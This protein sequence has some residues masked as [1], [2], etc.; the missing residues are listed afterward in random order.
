MFRNY[1]VTAIRHLARNKLYAGISIFGLSIGLCMALFAGLMIYQELSFEHFLPNYQRTFVAI[2]GMAPPDRPPMYFAQSPGFVAASMKRMFP[3]IAV[4]S[5]IADASVRLRRGQFET[6]EKVYWADPEVFD[7]LSFTAIAGD[8]RSALKRPDGIVLTQSIATRY[9]G[10]ENP[11]GQSLT[12]NGEHLQ[13]VTAVIR[14]LPIYG[15]SLESGIFVSGLAPY[16]MLAKCDHDDIENAKRGGVGLCGLTLFRL[17]NGASIDHLRRDELALISTFPPLPPLMQARVPFVRIDQLHF[18]DGLHPGARA[19]LGETA[20][21]GLLILFAACVVYVNL[22]TARSV[23]RATEVGVRKVCGAGRG[24]LAFQFLGES[25]LYVILGSLVAVSLTELSLPYLNAFLNTHIEFA[26]WRNPQLLGGVLLGVLA[27][28]ILSG[29][30]P[31]LVLSSFRPTQVLKGFV[32]VSG[33]TAA[34]RLLVIAQCAILIGLLTGAAVIYQQREFATHDAVRMN[35][36]HVVVVPG[37][38]VPSF[39]EN[40]RKRADIQA[41][42]CSDNAFLTSD[43]FSNS[44]LKDGSP[45]TVNEVELDFDVFNFYGIRLLAGVTEPRDSDGTSAQS[46]GR[47]IINASLARALGFRSPG[48]ALGQPL[49]LKNADDTGGGASTT[50]SEPPPQ[51]IIIAVVPDFAFA[52]ARDPLRPTLYR[53]LRHDLAPIREFRDAGAPGSVVNWRALVHFKLNERATPET[54]QAIDSLW[55][56]ATRGV[57]QG[58]PVPIQRLFLQDYLEMQYVDLLK[59][60]QTF[61]LF[62]LIAVILAGLGLLGLAAATAERRTKEIGIRKAMGAGR[63]DVL[64]MLLRQFMLPVLWASLI[65][66]PLSALILN[67]WLESF[68]QHIS[69]KPLVF[70]AAS[71]LAMIICLLTVIVYAWRVANAKPV[72]ALRYE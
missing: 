39:V 7:V 50:G 31:A 49:E 34:R 35:I 23:R 46:A 2:S 59:Q 43:A 71:G 28:G 16:S 19:R 69:L 15:T 29:A 37:P 65:A 40:L 3:E 18:F 38:C 57:S 64:W 5:R 12:L 53:P 58:S 10:N 25:L 48:A 56:V 27:V 14:D 41:A 1:I 32:G 63:G 17:R 8:L 51:P 68:A 54:L 9:F 26:Y 47:V 70:F 30:Y 62:S 11:L 61:G 55:T 44:E 45:I 24:A 22:T 52:A 60:A 67:R 20:A 6:K 42:T 4:I 66:W 21:V 13:Q 36:D 72:A 33:G